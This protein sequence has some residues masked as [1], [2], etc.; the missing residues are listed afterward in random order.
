[1]ES[2]SKGRGE[3]DDRKFGGGPRG[4]GKRGEGKWGLMGGGKRGI[5][6]EWEERDEGNLG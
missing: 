6:G 3:I 4:E 2:S 5:M 1:M